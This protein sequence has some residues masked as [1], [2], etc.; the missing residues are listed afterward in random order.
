MIEEKYVITDPEG[1]H[2]RPA[3]ELV[4]TAKEF[5]CKITLSKDGKLGDCKK[6]FGIMALAVKNGN[7]ITMTFDGDDEEA[8]RDKVMDFLKN[9]M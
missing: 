5:N 2:A 4:K 7:E 1:I 6:I 8:A 3:G 9:N